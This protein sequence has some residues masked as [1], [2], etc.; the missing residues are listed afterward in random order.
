M[1]QAGFQIPQSVSSREALAE[2]ES[3]AEVSKQVKTLS[4]VLD[5]EKHKAFQQLCRLARTQEAAC[6]IEYTAMVEGYL[7]FFL[8][9]QKEGG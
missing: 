3:I 8:E 4:R 9:S 5:E 2:L 1:T 6:F 7:E